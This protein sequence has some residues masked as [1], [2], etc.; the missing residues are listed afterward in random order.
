MRHTGGGFGG[1]LPAQKMLGALKGV[2]GKPP[3]VVGR[4]LYKIC[5]RKSTHLIRSGP[6]ILWG[7]PP[8]CR[9]PGQD[10]IYNTF[11]CSTATK[12]FLG[13]LNGAFDGNHFLCRPP[14]PDPFLEGFF[15]LTTPCRKLRTAPIRPQ[16]LQ[17][18]EA[19]PI[20]LP[21]AGL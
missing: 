15:Y 2:V 18:F 13:V 5:G 7:A 17:Q 1:F 3:H 16:R 12:T 20:R 9:K 10:T 11:C 6:N 4:V 8:K 19:P 14:P 21:Q